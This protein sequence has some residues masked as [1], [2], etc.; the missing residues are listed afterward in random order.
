MDNKG[1]FI[2]IR[3]VPQMTLIQ[4]QILV[5]KNV[6]K[7]RVWV[8]DTDVDF[9]I[10][11]FPADAWLEKN[12]TKESTHIWGIDT[13]A[14]VFSSNLTAALSKFL[15]KHVRLA[16]KGDEEPRV[17]LGKLAKELLGRE[18]HF[19]YQDL[20]PVL[21]ANASSLAELNERLEEKGEDSIPIERFRPNIILESDRDI[22]WE[23]DEWKTLRF[24]D[25]KEAFIADLPLRCARCLVPNV[26]AKTAEKHAKE[27]W[28]TLMSYRR[29]D[30]GIKFK[31][32]FG[33]LCAP[34]NEGELYVGMSVTVIETTKKHSWPKKR[35]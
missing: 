10:D 18:E 33:M 11:A 2:T 31:P 6:E 34:R 15:D 4:T 22:P 1:R 17:F 35:T 30:E 29:I 23:E 8:E 25:G 32:C 16:L 24:G 9:K 21:V 3:E 19:H 26:D 13:D 28:T 27:P 7:L 20:A 5:E 14:H 12:T